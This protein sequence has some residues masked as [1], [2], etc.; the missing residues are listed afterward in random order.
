MKRYKLIIAVALLISS[1]VLLFSKL[2]TPQPIQIVLETGQEITTQA[3]NYYALSEVLMLVTASFIIGATAIYLFYNSEQIA[4]MAGKEE[5]I[6]RDKFRHI[7]NLLKN[8]E[9]KVFDLLVEQ[10]G[11]MLQNKLVLKTELSKVSVTRALTKLENKNLIIKERYGLTN[12]IKLKQ[13]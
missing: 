6:S 9:K 11:E 10:N 3:P 5:K 2:F 8:N 1:I 7:A 12:K 13:D 4:S